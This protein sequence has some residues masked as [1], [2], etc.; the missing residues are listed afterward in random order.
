MQLVVTEKPSVAR[1]LARVLGVPA[2]GTDAFRGREHVITWCLG[3][4]VEL[5]EPASYDPAWKRWSFAALPMLPTA[6]K[7]RPVRRTAARWKALR[8]L[9]TD[10]SFAQ[11]VN[12]CDAGREGELIFR[13]C[14]ELARSRLP[15]LRLWVS[16]LTDAALRAALAKL[17]P[18]ARYD[19]LA[20]AARSRSEA[21]WLVGLNATRAMTCRQRQSSGELLSLGRVQTPTLALLVAREKA[22]RAFV[23]RDYWELEGSFRTLAAAP[24]RFTARWAHQ[25]RAR[26]ATAALADALKARCEAARGDD[27]PVVEHRDARTQRVP[28][29]LLFDLTALQRTANRRYGL[30]AARTLQVAQ[31][32]YETH[33][34]LTYPRTDSRYLSNDLRAELPRVW[35]ALATLPVY[36][37]F[38]ARTAPFTAKLPRVFDDGKVRDHHALL[39]TARAPVPERLSADER[40]LYD[41]VARRTLG[42]FFPDAEFAVVTAVVRVGRA[43]A[44]APA[45]PA[46]EPP[47]KDDEDPEEKL[48]LWEALPAAPDRFV[49]RGRTRVV[50][51]WQEVAGFDDDDPK[52]PALPALSVGQRLGGSYAARAKK[53]VAPRRY[54]EA[55]LLGAMESAGKAIDDEALR[56]AMKDHGL[57]TPATRAATVETLLERRY[58]TRQD[59]ALFPTT[60]GEALIDALPVEALRSAELTGRWEARLARMARGEEKRAAFMADIAEFVR[61]TVKVLATAPTVSTRAPSASVATAPAASTPQGRSRRAARAE[62]SAGGTKPARAVGAVKPSRAVD[63]AKPPVREGS[64]TQASGV[65]CPRCSVGTLIVGH[66]AWGCSRWRE[67][68]RVVIPYEAH[69]RRLTEAQARAL[70]TRGVT[71]PGSFTLAG[72]TIRGRLRLDLTPD[73]PE[74]LLDVVG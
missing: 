29:P 27:G 28:P 74:V 14:Y 69:G 49:A 55:T 56:E 6:F 19:A 7:L 1:D 59:K 10:R 25:G 68:C 31:A 40:R 11:V 62:R 38:T 53:T 24:E 63:D 26:L 60:L 70:A 8:A 23:P 5:D 43:E 22:L 13:H 39:P 46:P 52:A 44:L 47:R 37:P 35:A 65:P 36:A 12:A 16:S 33:K 18:G 32:L 67:G 21:D 45:P 15:V 48:P 2:T 66:A 51:G 30:S 57:G 54:T 42:A 9:L 64:G 72:A 34:L 58:V 4:L 61:A 71:R 73:R 50:A 20:D 17:E 3:H 41:L